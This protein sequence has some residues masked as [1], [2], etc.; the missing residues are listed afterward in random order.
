MTDFHAPPATDHVD[1]N[2]LNHARWIS[3]TIDDINEANIPLIFSSSDN[4]EK[5]NKNNKN[6]NNNNNN[7]N[8]H[9]ITPDCNEKF[10]YLGQ[11]DINRIITVASFPTLLAVALE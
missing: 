1:T 3:T 8:N 6:N 5:N 11:T 10:Q 9:V 4:I 2:N 7:K